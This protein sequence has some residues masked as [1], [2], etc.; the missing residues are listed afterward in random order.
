MVTEFME[1]S[2]GTVRTYKVTDE[3]LIQAASTPEV[4]DPVVEGAA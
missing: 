3:A 1:G 2:K 4:T